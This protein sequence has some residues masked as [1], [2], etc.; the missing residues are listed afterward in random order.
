MKKSSFG[1]L[2][3]FITLNVVPPEKGDISKFWPRE[4]KIAKELYQKFPDIEFWGRFSVG[5]KV[6][7]LAYFK[8]KDGEARLTRKYAEFHFN[9]E[10]K[11]NLLELSDGKFGET[12]HNS[13][14]PKTV[15]DFLN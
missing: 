6:K 14:A 10:N 7:S 13:K 1:F 12:I 4:M 8:M 5:F 15:K 11:E 2:K 9:P 3:H